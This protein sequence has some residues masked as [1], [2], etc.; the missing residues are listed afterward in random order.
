MGRPR[1]Q[2]PLEAELVRATKAVPFELLMDKDAI[3]YLENRRLEYVKRIEAIASEAEI[4][5]RQA[6]DPAAKIAFFNV[7]LKASAYLT[8]LTSVY[9][10]KID[11]TA[12]QLGLLKPPDLSKMSDADLKA[13][14][15]AVDIEGTEVKEQ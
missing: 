14:E 3:N 7:D 12:S 1:K 15:Q 8:R 10:Q 5:W 11:V 9:K 6:T 2:I 13:L 4:E